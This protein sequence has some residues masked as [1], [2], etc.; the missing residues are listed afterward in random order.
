[1]LVSKYHC[2]L[3]SFFGFALKKHLRHSILSVLVL[4]LNY[5]ISSYQQRRERNGE[6]RTEI[7]KDTIR[8]QT[9][10]STRAIR[11]RQ[12]LQLFGK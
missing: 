1:M 3:T 2:L 9:E 6:Q 8:D 12:E 11:T 10:S 4:L 7:Q 5:N